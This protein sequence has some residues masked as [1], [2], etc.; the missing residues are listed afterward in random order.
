MDNL[1]PEQRHKCMSHIHS[2]DTKPEVFFRKALWKWGIRYRKNVKD[3][4]GTPDIAIKKYKIVIFIDGDFWHGNDWKKKHFLSQ[5]ELLSTY[6]DY[7]QKKI[8]RNIER[9]KKVKKYYKNIGWT[10]LRFL[11]SETEKSLNKCI[12]KTIITIN[13]IKDEMVK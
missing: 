9:D 12:T 7:W 11:T 5:E 10:V 3:L 8:R 2:S 4:L 13:K 6:S 1:T